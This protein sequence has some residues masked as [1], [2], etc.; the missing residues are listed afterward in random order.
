MTKPAWGAVGSAG[1]STSLCIKFLCPVRS[2]VWSRSCSEDGHR[3][4]L[5][6]HTAT[7]ML[8]PVALLPAAYG[9]WLGLQKRKTKHKTIWWCLDANESSKN[10]K[11]RKMF[12]DTNLKGYIWGLEK[13]LSGQGLI[14]HEWG[15]ELISPEPTQMLGGVVSVLWFQHLEGRGCWSPRQT[16]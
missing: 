4:K 1:E 2:G 14:A 16:G 5:T 7:I 11:M 12:S 9:G 6:M 15:L 10:F 8:P 13:C 3:H